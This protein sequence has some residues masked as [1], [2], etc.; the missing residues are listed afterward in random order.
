M[1]VFCD[2]STDGTQSRVFAMAGLVGREDDWVVAEQTWR[3]LTRGEVFHA[4]DWEHLGRLDEYKELTLALAGSKIAGRAVAVDL[5]AVQESFPEILPDVGYYKCLLKVV[6]WLVENVAA[7][8]NEPIEFTFDNRE[9]SNFNARKLYQSMVAK[10]DWPAAV[11]MI[12]SPR[13]D[14]RQNPRMQ[15]ADLVAREA[16]KDLNCQLGPAERERRKSMV[17]LFTRGHFN[18]GV[19]DR[20]YCESWRSAVEKT[21]R[22]SNIGERLSRWLMERRLDDNWSN[23]IAF[24]EWLESNEVGGIKP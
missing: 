1:K 6:S 23:R 18:F 3:G 15:M 14:S 9:H 7:K 8:L 12:E 4:A 21:E 10:S 16:M 19:I 13:F 17:S 11:L 5:A 24:M 22:M 20:E 2:E